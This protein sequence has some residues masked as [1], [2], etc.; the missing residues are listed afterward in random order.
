VQANAENMI[1]ISPFYK[2]TKSFW[3]GILCLWW[4]IHIREIGWCLVS[5]PCMLYACTIKN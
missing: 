2:P 1:T 4:G 5:Q 3:P